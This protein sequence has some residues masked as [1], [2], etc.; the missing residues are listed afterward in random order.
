MNS[1]FTVNLYAVK[2]DATGT[3]DKV[4]EYPTDQAAIR[5][6]RHFLSSDLNS[7]YALSPS[8]FSL[9]RLGSVDRQSGMFTSEQ[10]LLTKLQFL[11]E[12]AGVELRS[13]GA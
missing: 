10:E 1:P 9:W 5:A 11:V 7:L 3:F 6:L 8:D 13:V 2:D 12:P 4:L